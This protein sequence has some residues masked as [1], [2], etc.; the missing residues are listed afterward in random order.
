M[1]SQTDQQQ[2]PACTGHAGELASRAGSGGSVRSGESPNSLTNTRATALLA[3]VKR[4]R[5]AG[6]A[7]GIG[8]G[9]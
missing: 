6:A 1:H 3:Q 4:T 5:R 8:S 2:P 7:P 9:K